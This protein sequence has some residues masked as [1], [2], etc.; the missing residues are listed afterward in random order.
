[1][2]GERRAIEIRSDSAERTMLLGE[3]IG[4]LIRAG[5]VV[6]LHGDLGAGKTCLVRGVARG[7]GIDPGAVNSPTFVV[8]NEY[9]APAGRPHLVHMD[10]YRLGGPEELD[11]LGLDESLRGGALV[12]EWAERVAAAFDSPALEVHLRHD[13]DDRRSILIQARDGRWADRLA[14]LE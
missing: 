13:G 1:M 2:P 5:D 8:V 11:D 9:D 14:D 6:L 7:M 12:V 4:R 3:R 10:A